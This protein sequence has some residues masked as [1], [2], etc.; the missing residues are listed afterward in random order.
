MKNKKKTPPKKT[1]NKSLDQSASSTSKK[2]RA[3]PK[4]GECGEEGITS[5]QILILYIFFTGDGI[6][7]FLSKYVRSWL[8]AATSDFCLLSPKY[9]TSK[10]KIAVSY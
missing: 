2:P 10:I 7:K 6:I 1:A 9:G 5:M 3:A 4:C 8:T